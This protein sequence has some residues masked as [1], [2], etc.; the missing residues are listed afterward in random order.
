MSAIR[1]FPADEA[2]KTNAFRTLGLGSLSDATSCVVTEERNGEYEL[3]MEY[4]VDGI[5]ANELET[6]RLIVCNASEAGKDQIFRIYKIEK[7]IDGKLTVNAEHI[8]YLLNRAMCLPFTMEDTTGAGVMGTIQS[9]I[10]WKPTDKNFPTFP[11]TFWSDYDSKQGT[12]TVEKPT[13]V[14]L[15]L[16]GQEGSLLDATSGEYEFDNFTVK[17]WKDR[18]KDNGVTLRYGKN[19]TDLTNTDDI[20]KAYTGILP[21]WSGS[22]TRVVP[23]TPDQDGK[24]RTKTES[25]ETIVYLSDK[26]DEKIM[27]STE[28][29]PYA[30]PLAS[31]VDCSSDIEVQDDTSDPDNPKYATEDDV[32]KQLKTV[33]E[34]YLK[35][36]DGWKPANNL[37]VSYVQLWDTEEYKNFLAIQQVNLCDTVHV[38]YSKLNINVT[39]KVIKTEYNVLLDRYDKIELG[40]A[41]SSMAAS[42]IDGSKKNEDKLK[43]LAEQTKSD[44]KKAA[45]HATEM[46]DGQISTLAGVYGGYITF[47]RDSLGHITEI[48]IMDSDKKSEAV[49]VWRWNAGGLGHSHSG[50]RGPYDDVALTAD[51]QINANLITTGELNASIIKTGILTDKKG[52]F[53]LDMVSGKLVMKDGTYSGVIDVTGSKTTHIDG[54]GIYTQWLDLS[55]RNGEIWAPNFWVNRK[56]MGQTEIKGKLQIVTWGNA[57][58]ASLYAISEGNLTIEGSIYATGSG[59]F[60]QS[61]RR[62]KEEIKEIPSEESLQTILDLKPVSFR[63]KKFPKTSHHGFIAQDV[64]ESIGDS[65]WGVWSETDAGNGF[66]DGQFL[67]YEEIIADLVGSVKK[68]NERIEKLEEVIKGD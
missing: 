51:G 30:Y 24:P 42:V 46:I 44:L 29:N 12:V 14:R 16:G 37:E 39:M 66:K 18:G 50:Y 21:Y 2:V 15:V 68:L 41:K 7:D 67:N 54:S 17:Y 11:F 53:Y 56:G 38:Y 4:P 32:R 13:S 3:E 1:L 6:D 27:W 57:L 59:N 62:L 23:D 43:E 35:T 25:Y 47:E 34:N 60:N 5:H 63:F 48:L 22:L 49:Q 26:D 52:I 8:S 28:N 65:D 10:I 9:H 19:I 40:E 33:A 58:G 36:N 61:D 64:K 31:V 45:D 55:E 20:S